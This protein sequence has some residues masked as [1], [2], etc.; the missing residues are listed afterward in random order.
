MN[1]K[2]SSKID[3]KIESVEIEQAMLFDKYLKKGD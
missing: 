2:D 3:Q 1:Y